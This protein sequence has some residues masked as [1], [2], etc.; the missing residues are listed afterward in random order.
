MDR[1]IGENGIMA[2]DRDALRKRAVKRIKQFEAPELGAFYISS[3]TERERAEDEYAIAKAADK[4]EEKEIWVRLRARMIQRQ[5][6]DQDGNRLYSDSKADL[7]EILSLDSSV[8]NAITD[9][10]EQYCGRIK[11]TAV[12]TDETIKN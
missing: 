3:M 10:I 7:D 12:D 6:C 11:P 2:L 4:G 1:F 8:T 9:A 5:L